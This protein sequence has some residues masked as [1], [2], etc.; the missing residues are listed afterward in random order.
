MR[1]DDEPGSLFDS[2]TDC[3][4]KDEDEE[5]TATEVEDLDEE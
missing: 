4:E 5:S 3:F 2:A 1:Y